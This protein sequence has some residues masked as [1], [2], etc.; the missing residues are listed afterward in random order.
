MDGTL[1]LRRSEERPLTAEELCRT[2]GSEVC[3]F[4][5]LMTASAQDAEDL[6]QE[7]LLRAVRSLRSYD[8][9]RGTLESWLWRI[10]AN[11]ARD[12]AGTRQRLHDLALR[13]G[14]G[15]PGESE[16]VEELVLA[17]LRD[18]ELHAC[19]LRLPVRDRTLLALRFGLD[20]D[21][22]HVGAAVGL[23]PDSARKAVR[24]ALDRLRAQLEVSTR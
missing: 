24:R 5:A 12:A 6:A 2:H 20:L 15:T 18:E 17:R 9:S 11:A 7:A 13:I 23:S 21:L 3:R 19:L 14:L 4:A 10:V 16:S 22:K 8:P 1:T